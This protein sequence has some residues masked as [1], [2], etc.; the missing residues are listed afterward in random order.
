MKILKNLA[1]SN[2]ALIGRYLNYLIKTGFANAI[3]LLAL[4][5]VARMYES[6]DIGK[7]AL[8]AAIVSVLSIASM[9]SFQNLVIT[10]RS[11]RKAE[12]LYSSCF[13]LAAF[14]SIIFFLIYEFIPRDLFK[15]FLN[16]NIEL[17]GLFPITL[18][19]ISLNGLNYS[20][21]VRLGLFDEIAKNKLILAFSTSVI[22]I[23]FGIL[24]LGVK[25]LV[26][27]NIIGLALSIYIVKNKVPK[28]KP[29]NT[30]FF[31]ISAKIFSKNINIAKHVLPGSLID[32][33][34][35][36]LPDF[37]IGGLFGAWWLGQYAM[38]Q[39]LI[40][41]PLAFL[42]NAVQDIF[43]HKIAATS[44]SKIAMKKVIRKYLSLTIPGALLIYVMIRFCSD[45]V[46]VR[47]LGENW[48]DASL[49]IPILGIIYLVQFVASPLSYTLIVTKKYYL[50]F[51]WQIFYL[52]IS[53]F[54]LFAMPKIYKFKDIYSFVTIMTIGVS[55]MYIVY[56]VI[57]I[58]SVSG[59]NNKKME[60]I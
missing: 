14:T 16:E 59:G 43:R 26:L 13:Y 10:S 46:V 48:L 2:I 51:V 20:W 37:A 25:G 6:G 11:R 35:V 42:T 22:Q 34:A 57:S 30:R 54:L 28:L 8:F 4:P 47:L 40:A 3:P 32:N 60:L 41:V 23:C 45:Q 31:A 55:I 53:T 18:V 15:Y 58:A 1:K 38:A 44:N 5:F 56:M 21:L 33:L 19:L 9:L 36:R 24:S 17:F 12:F 29:V 27:A 49:L 7:Y 39:R 50:S 52:S